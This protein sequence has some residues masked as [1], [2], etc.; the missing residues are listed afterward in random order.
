MNVKTRETIE[1]EIYSYSLEDLLKRYIECEYIFLI[2]SD[3][4]EKT[5]IETLDTI[6]IAEERLWQ[7]E[8]LNTWIPMYSRLSPPEMLAN[9]VLRYENYI[10][11]AETLEHQHDVIQRTLWKFR[12]FL[13]ILGHKN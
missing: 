8:L 1:N 12:T 13:Y 4:D 3:I 10:K 6:E 2:Q 11:R 9:K 5:W 7:I